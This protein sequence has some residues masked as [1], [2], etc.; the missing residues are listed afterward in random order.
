MSDTH[1][2]RD[3]YLPRKQI[4]VDWPAP[5]SPLLQAARMLSREYG[6]IQ[7]ERHPKSN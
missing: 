5:L 6:Y 7:K 1:V 4:A 2:F 3:S